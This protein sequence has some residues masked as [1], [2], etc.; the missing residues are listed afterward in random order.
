MQKEPDT[1]QPSTS[2][3]S[4]EL[5]RYDFRD[6]DSQ[7][8]FACFSYNHTIHNSTGFSPPELFY[9]RSTYLPIERSEEP[10]PK[11][12]HN[13]ISTLETLFHT[14]SENLLVRKKKSK[15]NFDQKSTPFFY[16]VNDTAYLRNFRK[17]DGKSDEALN[18]LWR[19]PFKITG[20]KEPNVELELE[21]GNKKWYHAKLIKPGF[22]P[23]FLLLLLSFGLTSGNE[24][25]N[26]TRID[27][28]QR[29]FF[30]KIGFAMN[31][32]DTWHF[33][34]TYNVTDLKERISILDIQSDTHQF[35]TRFQRIY[36]LLDNLPHLVDTT[37][38]PPTTYSRN[39]REGKFYEGIFPWV[40]SIASWILGM[41]TERDLNRVEGDLKD[42]VKCA[43][44]GLSYFEHFLTNAKCTRQLIQKNFDAVIQIENQTQ[45]EIIR[46]EKLHHVDVLTS[47]LEQEISD[48][49]NALLLAKRKLVHPELITYQQLATF[50]SKAKI[51]PLRTF[52]FSVLKVT[53]EHYLY[54]STIQTALLNDLL[55]YDIELPLTEL[56]GYDI[57]QI[58]PF[59]FPLQPSLYS[60]L[61]PSTTFLIVNHART[62]HLATNT[63]KD[64]TPI[65]H[66]KYL[67]QLHTLSTAATCEMDL[68][69]NLDNNC[70]YQEARF[71]P[72]SFTQLDKSTWLFL[73]SETTNRLQF[74]LPNDTAFYA[75]LPTRGILSINSSC[76]AVT[77]D[78]V[79]I[80][81][82]NYHN[83]E[84]HF[85]LDLPNVTHTHRSLPNITLPHLRYL[86]TSTLDQI[87]QD[88]RLAITEQRSLYEMLTDYSW[89]FSYFSIFLSFVVIYC[90][91]R[92]CGC[93]LCASCPSYPTSTSTTNPVSITVNTTVTPSNSITDLLRSSSS[94]P[95][96]QPLLED[97]TLSRL[98]TKLP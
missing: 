34:T 11:I 42:E 37:K 8:P 87:V 41:A 13:T 71:T 45:S 97:V 51:P 64:C 67:C 74:I 53:I 46:T 50:I 3:A 85:F 16:Q 70:Q 95:A 4:R 17:S 75:T 63:L 94:P 27:T 18:P 9:G 72:S 23:F 35:D 40:G 19:G 30:H 1:S 89:H 56:N 54:T 78:H 88:T 52:P 93:T 80:S 73:T 12:I 28:T 25:Y 58:F 10:Q 33:I 77:T 59:P 57:F 36:D 14:A 43:A 69:Q 98:H 2:H 31:N 15:E 61:L 91:L 47:L 84:Q 79:L 76:T 29:L 32:V 49:V 86:D 6:W 44:K 26:T 38:L 65:L 48:L 68:L 39:K 83:V 55:F 60:L 5:K 24:I 96:T 81:H 22:L 66:G 21:N 90:I 82:H 7:L 62:H 20:I 92:Y